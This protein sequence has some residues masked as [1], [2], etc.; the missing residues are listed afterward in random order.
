MQPSGV[1]S[2]IVQVRIQDR[3]RKFTLGRYPEKSLADGRKEVA[4]LLARVWAGEAV[5]ERKVKAPLFRDF[6]ACYRERRKHRWKPASLKTFD[7]YMRNRLMPAFGK[8]RLDA[9]D[10][11]HVSAWFDAASVDKPGAAN[12][13]QCD[14]GRSRRG[15]PPAGAG[16][17][18]AAIIARASRRRRL[19]RAVMLGFT[20][21]F[22]W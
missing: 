12:R 9:I 22:L 14:S 4:A 7:G 19:A 20:H 15:K 1:R 13:E 16:L 17:G 6:A 3:M 5:P 18:H 8:M 11:A 2:F 21:M 10:H